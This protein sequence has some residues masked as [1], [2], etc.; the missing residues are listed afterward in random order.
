MKKNVFLL[1]ALCA[2]GV[3]AAQAAGSTTSTARSCH[4][5]DLRLD[6][7]R[8]AYGQRRGLREEMH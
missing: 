6:V 7:R 3:V 8:Q 2:M 1:A 4:G 5:M